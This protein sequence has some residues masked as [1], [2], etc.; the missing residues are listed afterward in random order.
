MRLDVLRQE[1]SRDEGDRH[2][3]YCDV[4]GKT[5]A[6]GHLCPGGSVTIGVGHNLSRNPISQRVC[7]LLF[8]GDLRE[9][10]EGAERVVPGFQGLTDRRQEAFVNMVYQMGASGVANF[11]KAMARVRE[12]D[13]E[14]ARREILDSEYGRKHPRRAQRVAQVVFEG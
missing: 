7:D 4:C 14:G 5:C 9:A 2:D 11:K 1:I 13:W 8:E 3:P 10:I 6:N 12:E